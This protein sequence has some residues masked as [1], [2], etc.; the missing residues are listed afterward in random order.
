[1][2]PTKLTLHTRFQISPVDPRIFGGFLEHLGRAVYQGVYEPQSAHAD[3]D[4]FRSDVMETLRRQRRAG[5]V[6]VAYILRLC[7]FTGTTTSCWN[8]SLA[9]FNSCCVLCNSVGTVSAVKTCS[10]SLVV[11]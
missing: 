2:K 3:E 4:G 7:P 9:A 6:S 11:S 8:D 10:P 1:M 5:V